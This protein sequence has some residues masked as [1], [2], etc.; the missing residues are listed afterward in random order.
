MVAHSYTRL[1]VHPFSRSC[2]RSLARALI[3]WRVRLPA[4]SHHNNIAQTGSTRPLARSYAHFCPL[5]CWLLRSFPCQ[6]VSHG[7]D[8][9]FTH[10]SSRPIQHNIADATPARA[11]FLSLVC[12]SVCSCVRSLAPATTCPFTPRQY[13][14]DGEHSPTCSLVRP[15]V[16]SAASL[17]AR[18]RSLGSPTAPT[19]LM[20]SHAAVLSLPRSSVHSSPRLLARLFTHAVACLLV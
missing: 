10:S 7:L 5:A 4:C 9:T 6:R 19:V 13:C 8:C 17:H 1:F 3:P 15:F 2:A 11:F 20:P 14:R 16:R 18:F 12:L